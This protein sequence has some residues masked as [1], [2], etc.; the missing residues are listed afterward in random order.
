MNDGR[1]IHICLEGNFEVEK[2]TANQIY[3]LRDLLGSLT[4]KYNI[5]KDNI[6]FHRDISQTACP[7]ANMDKVF[8]KSLVDPKVV[9]EAAKEVKRT[10][11]VIVD[12]I[13][14]LLREL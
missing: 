8:V 10:K 12:E 4:N 6:L 13:I 7:G 14:K 5:S 11:K 1:A 9:E 2:P 3:K